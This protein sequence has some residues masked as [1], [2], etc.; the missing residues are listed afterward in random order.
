MFVAV[1][2]VWRCTANFFATLRIAV[3]DF[4]TLTIKYGND[5]ICIISVDNNK[6]GSFMAKIVVYGDINL[7]PLYLKIDGGKE[8][9]V[10]GK[11]AKSF[12]IS[13]GTHHVFATTVT[14]IE[15]IGNRFS[16][17]SF[18]SN[19]TA[20]VQ[21]STN[22]TLSGEVDI[23]E[24]EVLLIFVEQKGLKTIVSGKLVSTDEADD[25]LHTYKV[26]EHRAKKRWKKI[27]VGLVLI[28]VIFLLFLFMFVFT[29][30]S[31]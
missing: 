3:M 12:S 19:L 17:G 16:D 1:R 6:G 29:T 21:D 9:A 10:S 30:A 31:S 27:L 7:F 18:V 4:K 26:V 25:Y 5:I 24:D 13:A 22:T 11:Y 28:F 8:V 2:R 15:R 23:G 14:K 20:A